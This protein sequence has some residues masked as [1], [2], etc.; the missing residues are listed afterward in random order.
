MKEPIL[1]QALLEKRYLFA[2]WLMKF[3]ENVNEPT[4]T[5]VDPV[6]TLLH[7]AMYKKSDAQCIRVLVNLGANIHAGDSLNRTPLHWAV[8][9]GDCPDMV[10]V[11]IDIGAVVDARDDHQMTPLHHVAANNYI[12]TAE[13]LIARGASVEAV[14]IYGDHV[15]HKAV[16]YHNL[17]MV[18][19][20]ISH[21]VNIDAKD[22][23]FGGTPLLHYFYNDFLEQGEDKTEIVSI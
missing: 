23:D 6:T 3:G 16:W 17:E 7:Y 13:K 5:E 20:L 9:I 2:Y 11:L 14:D 21:R 8:N 18:K 12:E 10:E 15:L 4:K 1:W 19:M 22:Y